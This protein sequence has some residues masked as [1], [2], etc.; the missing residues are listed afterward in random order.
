M[1][2]AAAHP[3]FCTQSEVITTVDDSA[4]TNPRRDNDISIP[5]N[6]TTS[7]TRLMSLLFM[8][9]LLIQGVTFFNKSL[10]N[11]PPPNLNSY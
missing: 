3:Y 10:K 7:Q 1:T 11:P 2:D 6:T 8:I 9:F 5:L 4:L